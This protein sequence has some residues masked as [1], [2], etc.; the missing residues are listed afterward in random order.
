MERHAIKQVARGMK[1][2]M[3]LAVVVLA[4][5]AAL[6]SLARAQKVDLGV[7]LSTALAPPPILTNGATA[8]PA[9]DGGAYPG[10]SRVGVT[11]GCTLP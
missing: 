6:P 7:G 8:Y 11:V 5:L 4:G 2:G 9:F 1:L 10:A 3:R